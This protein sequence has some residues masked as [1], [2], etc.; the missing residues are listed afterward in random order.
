[1]A[2]PKSKPTA[3]QSQQQS[4]QKVQVTEQR[5]FSG[6]IPPPDVLEHYD[7]ISNGL[8]NRI[9][10]MAENEQ[11]HRRELDIS[12]LDANKGIANKEFSERRIGQVFGL[13]IGIS[14]LAC[15]AYLGYLGLETAAATVGGTTVVSLVGLF[16]LGKLFNRTNHS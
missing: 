14:G 12:T 9:V 15:A 10:A 3:K 7:A 1:M 8:A 11:A 16:I 5:A 6:P 13:I 2:R 4:Q